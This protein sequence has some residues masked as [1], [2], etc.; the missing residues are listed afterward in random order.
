MDKVT[1]FTGRTA[2]E[3]VARA[4]SQG[5]K[6]PAIV[7]MLEITTETL[8]LWS[9]DPD[10]IPQR[11]KQALLARFAKVIARNERRKA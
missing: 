6:T 4:R 1:V 11:G 5:W 3:L 10:V 9:S 2:T 8:R 7:G